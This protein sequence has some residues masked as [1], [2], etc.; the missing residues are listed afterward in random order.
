[1]TARAASGDGAGPIYLDWNATTPL[2]PRVREAMR[3]AEERGWANPASVHGA[4]RAARAELES[5][6]EALAAALGFH[7][8][9]VAFTAS[10]TEANNLALHDAPMLVTSRIEHPSVVALA[11]QLE[12]RGMPVRW[13][14]VGPSGAVEPASVREALRE[15]G[16]RP[17]A[18][19]EGP[20]GTACGIRRPTVAVM[21]AN[22][23]TGV[24]QPLEAIAEVVHEVGAALHVDA[25]Q[26]VGRGDV[27]AL[28]HADS[29]SLAAHKLRGPKGIGALLWRAGFPP[30]PLLRGGAQERGLRPGTLDA[31]AAA[32]F[33]AAIERAPES[34]A[35]YE[36]LGVLRDRFEVEL[37]RVARRNGEGRRLAHVSN[38]S[39]AGWRGDEVVAALDL[40]G[41]FVSSGSAC[42]AGTTEPS[43]VISTLYDRARASEAVRVS[44]GEE[45]TLAEVE[46]ALGTFKRVLGLAT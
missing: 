35:A 16:L 46:R 18:P 39:V 3:A 30:R 8:R 42:S 37:A 38:L 27:A 31:T 28:S 9:D 21:A 6:R 33:R 17:V 11:E 40:H 2:H 5:T 44:L 45:T 43:A 36:A 24:L 25:V 34:R 14:P 20:Q 32:G 22:H 15:L 41:V 7:P 26:L 23:E 10:G 19:S 29:V 13:L 12:Q 4:G 1:M